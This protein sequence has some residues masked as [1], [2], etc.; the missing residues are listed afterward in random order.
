MKKLE[1]GAWWVEANFPSRQHTDEEYWTGEREN[2]C[3]TKHQIFI[4]RY[5][6]KKKVNLVFHETFFY[7]LVFRDTFYGNGLSD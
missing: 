2:N 1:K 5:L 7:N 6:K 3:P 4:P